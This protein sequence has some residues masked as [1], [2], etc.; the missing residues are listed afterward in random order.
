MPFDRV[1]IAGLVSLN[2]SSGAGPSSRGCFWAAAVRTRATQ[3]APRVNPLM[4]FLLFMIFLPSVGLGLLDEDGH[5]PVLRRQAGLG[6]VHDVRGRHAYQDVLV[7]E[8]EL[9]VAGEEL[10]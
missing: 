5:G 1:N 2:L 7:L 10:V 6:E 3:T 4:I 8:V 9:P